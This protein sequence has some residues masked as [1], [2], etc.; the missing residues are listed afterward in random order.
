MPVD[1]PQRG[2]GDAIVIR[3]AVIS[4]DGRYRYVLTRRW[5]QDLPVMPW[6]GLNPSTADHAIDDPTVRRMCGF[7]RRESCGG[8]CLL[9]LFALRATD[10]AVLQDADDPAGPDNDRW[11]ASMIEDVVLGAVFDQRRVV[12]VVAAW[13]SHSF[14][15][16]RARQVM[17]ILVRVPL[18]SLGATA[19]GAPRHPLYLK[20]STPF[21]PYPP[22]LERLPEY[23]GFSG[24]PGNP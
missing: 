14:A 13:G 11:L 24:R 21:V 1:R 8:I 22:D 10:P 5:D 18:V 4:G 20:G 17:E 3:D 19:L 23:R 9:N 15:G 2:P 12:P 16:E 6:I 7:A